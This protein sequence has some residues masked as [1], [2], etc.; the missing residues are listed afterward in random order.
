MRTNLVIVRKMCAYGERRLGFDSEVLIPA[1]GPFAG[2]DHCG[3][4][5]AALSTERSLDKG[6]TNEKRVQHGTVRKF[7]STFS[8]MWQASVEGGMDTIAVRDLSIF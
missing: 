1:M 7:R 2:Q 5:V 6:T 4:G 3:M 8:N